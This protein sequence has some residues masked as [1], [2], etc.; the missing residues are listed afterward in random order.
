MTSFCYRLHSNYIFRNPPH[1]YCLKIEFL[2]RHVSFNNT[3]RTIILII[4]SILA[5]S[6][7]CFC[8]TQRP[9]EIKVAE[10]GAGVLHGSPILPDVNVFLSAFQVVFSQSYFLLHKANDYQRFRYL[11][12]CM[13]LK[14]SSNILN[15]FQS[16]HRT[17]VY[18]Y[19]LHMKVYEHLF[20]YP[21]LYIEVR[22]L[23]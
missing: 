20:F 3:K 12:K 21:C 1:A 7:S 8:C 23:A 2:F 6:L 17:N 22:T 4:K 14:Y 9:G 19:L 15:R 18:V 16:I 13:L 11:F 10:K 5:P